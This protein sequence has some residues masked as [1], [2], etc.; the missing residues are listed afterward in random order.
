MFLNLIE[1]SANG[2]LVLKY[3]LAEG[4]GRFTYHYMNSAFE[5]FS[6]RKIK[7]VKGQEVTD[8]FPLYHMDELKSIYLQVHQSS[9]PIRF[10]EINPVSGR[11]FQVT[12]SEIESG[13]LALI[14]NDITEFKQQKEQVLE[15]EKR[16]RLLADYSTDVIS[17]HD[18]NSTFLFV[19]KISP[20]VLG[21]SVEEL[22]GKKAF[23]FVHPED[24]EILKSEMSSIRDSDEPKRY[25]YRFRKKD[26]SY[27][28][29]ETATRAIRKENNGKVIEVINVS[30]DVTSRIKAEKAVSESEAKFRALAESTSSCIIFLRGE[31]FLY[32]NKSAINFFGGNPNDPEGFCNSY[33]M[34]D[35]VHPEISGDIEKL[36]LGIRKVDGNVTENYELKILT[37]NGKTR[38]I[39]YTVN[40]VDFEEWPVILGTFF[41]ISDRKKVEKILRHEREEAVAGTKAKSEFIENIS[42]EI[43]TPMNA[44]LGFAHLLKKQIQSEPH[45]SWLE[46]ISTSGRTLIR[47]INDILD[48]SRMEHG[49]LDIQPEEVKLKTVFDEFP[50]LFENEIKAKGLTF[51]VHYEPSIPSLLYLDEMRLRQIL[52]NLVG[53]AIKFT[54]KGSITVSVQRNKSKVV[55]NTVD[56][57]IKVSDTGIGIPDEEQSKIFRRFEQKSG[58]SSYKYGGSGLGLAISKRLAE[59]MNGD[60]TVES[61]VNKG[62]T[63]SVLLNG[64]KVLE[65]GEFLK[66]EQEEFEPDEVNFEGK[67]VLVV[68]DFDMN[69]SLLQFYLS[70]A[71]I[72]LT[73]AENGEEAIEKAREIHPDIILLDM[74]MPVMNG[75]EALEILKQD[76]QLHTIPVIIV[77]ASTNKSELEKLRDLGCDGYLEKPVDKSNLIL[78]M[79]RHL[80]HSF[81]S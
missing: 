44:I 5:L 73:M 29:L 9:V 76:E 18:K 70:T 68:D 47:L 26:D 20:Q 14:I 21:Y 8:P 56:L 6:D 77:T 30:R 2:V 25:I 3:H 62:T 79:M 80:T 38:W 67:R 78:E 31:Q 16:Y 36:G 49:K 69:R 74:K 32:A 1:S 23:D 46:A 33:S 40:F 65:E 50:S 75:S 35:L 24:V 15:S 45:R 22:L 59:L 27:I 4:E 28:W 10:S 39:D 53:N 13:Y 61:S 11:F 7:D 19:S 63:F 72:E 51:A 60:I 71:N 58:Q 37:L 17:R 12:A 54:E 43:R 57:I 55:I 52:Y 48:F 34:N 64:V 42:H 81:Q 66:S 41:D